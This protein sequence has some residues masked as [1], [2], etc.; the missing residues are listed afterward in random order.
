MFNK[1]IKIDILHNPYVRL[2]AMQA[3]GAIVWDSE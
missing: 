3:V 2:A 1:Q